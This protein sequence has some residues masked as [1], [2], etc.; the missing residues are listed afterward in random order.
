MKVRKI[1]CLLLLMLSCCVLGGCREEENTSEVEVAQEL[2]MELETTTE[3]LEDTEATT[4][5]MTMEET[6]TEESTTEEVVQEPVEIEALTAILQGIIQPERD[7]G[8]IVSVEVRDLNTG[9]YVSLSQGQQQ[10]ASLI[11]LYV[12]ACVYERMDPMKQTESYDGEIEDLIC[13]MIT[14]SDNDATNTLV[15]KLGEGDANIGMANVNQYCLNHGFMETYMGRLML[16]FS[17][18]SDNYTSVTD[19]T[20]FLSAIYNGEIE[21]SAEILAYMK[22]QDRVGKLPAGVPEGVQTAN[23][24]GELEDV[25]NDVALV[26]AENGTYIVC[27]MMSDLQDTSVGRSVIVD[28]SKQIYNYMQE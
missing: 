2:D 21:G 6:T 17:S 15:T 14:V 10:S 19:C 16:D 24:T 13:K 5:K 1:R 23:K 11:K 26:F 20:R 28:I 25:E 27:V 4:E 7:K 22:Q 3:V 8:S 12:A 9:N 18:T